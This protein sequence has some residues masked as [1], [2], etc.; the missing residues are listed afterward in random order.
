MSPSNPYEP[1]QT[2]GEMPPL[3]SLIRVAVCY[4]VFGMI[5]VVL[6]GLGSPV[7]E[8]DPAVILALP[9]LPL[10]IHL[11]TWRCFR[12]R[13]RETPWFVGLFIAIP[14]SCLLAR[15]VIEELIAVFQLQ[16]LLAGNAIWW[17]WRALFGGFI[18]FAIELAVSN[19][20]LQRS[21]MRDV[22]IAATVGVMSI[23]VIGI[24]SPLLEPFVTFLQPR[25]RMWQIGPTGSVAFA[26]MIWILSVMLSTGFAIHRRARQTSIDEARTGEFAYSVEPK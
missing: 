2:P 11:A 26:N 5:P 6:C 22:R 18:A 17:C 16:D 9:L 23:G 4:T 14:G 13:W 20:L 10:A 15:V 25:P 3:V 1:P 21:S 19:Q 8:G 12:L 24:M 7:I